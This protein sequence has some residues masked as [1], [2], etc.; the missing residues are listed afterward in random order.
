MRIIIACDGIKFLQTYKDFL[1]MVYTVDSASTVE[2]TVGKPILNK[3]A[4]AL[5][6]IAFGGTNVALASK[7]HGKGKKNGTYIFSIE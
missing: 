4:V 3:Y 2:K 7:H 6:N 1:S 5:I